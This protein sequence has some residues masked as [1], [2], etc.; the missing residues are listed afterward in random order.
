MYIPTGM[1]NIK[2][3]RNTTILLK[4]NSISE[5]LVQF[6]LHLFILPQLLNLECLYVSLVKPSATKLAA[7]NE[8]A[9]TYWKS[10]GIGLY[11]AWRLEWN[12]GLENVVSNDSLK[13]T[14]DTKLYYK[15]VRNVF[16]YFVT[17]CSDSHDLMVLGACCGHVSW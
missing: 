4:N 8:T 11:C 2:I 15:D 7:W 17:V 13:S 1:S 9:V 10:I 6:F 12:K 5:L 16:A 14:L 3:V